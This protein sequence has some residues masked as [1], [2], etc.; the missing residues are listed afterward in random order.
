MPLL[1]VG[2]RMVMT[3]KIDKK[4]VFQI[5]KQEHLTFLLGVPTI[6]Q[7]MM[8]DPAFETADFSEIGRIRCGAAPASLEIMRAYWKKGVRFCNGYGMTEVG[9]GVLAMPINSMSVKDIEEKRLSVGKPMVYVKLRIVNEKGEDVP[10]GEKGELLIRSAAM[11]SGYWGDP[12]E[13]ELALQNGWM[14]S[15]DIAQQ[16]EEGYYYIVGRKKN[17]FISHGENIYPVEIENIMKEYPGIHEVCVI[18][19]PDKRKGEVGKAIVVLKEGSKATAEDIKEYCSKN[20][21]K[22]KQPKYVEIVEEIPRN[23]VGK[24]LMSKVHELYGNVD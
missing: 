16:D 3:R 21:A 6:F 13:T 15:G 5:M 4:D 19:V 17:M 8:E 9:P 2:A 18:G 7:Y 22:I 12:K 11:F 20:L 14:H 1:Y 24:V 10:K 23:S